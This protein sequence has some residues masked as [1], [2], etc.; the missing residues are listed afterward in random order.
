MKRGKAK[1]RMSLVLALLLSISLVV[2]ACGGND[3]NENNSATNQGGTETSQGSTPETTQSGGGKID[4]SSLPTAELTMMDR[5]LTGVVNQ[6]KDPI[7][8]ELEKIL[9]VKLTFE[10]PAEP[11]Y[12]QALSLLLANGELPDIVNDGYFFNDFTVKAVEE[13]YLAN[14]SDYVFADPDRY[15]TLYKMFNDPLWKFTNK[16]IWG[17]E[18]ANYAMWDFWGLISPP[19]GMSMYNGAVL[20]QVNGG[21]TPKTFDEFIDYLYKVKEQVPGV[22]PLSGRIDAG[23]NLWIMFTSV[24]FRTHGAD[25]YSIEDWNG[26]DVYEETATSDAAKAQWKLIGKLYKDGIMEPDLLTRGSDRIP[27]AVANFANGKY[28]VFLSNAPGAYGVGADWFVQEWKKVDPNV[29]IGKDLVFDQAPIQ[30]PG[31]VAN[32]LLPEIAIAEATTSVSADS[33]YIDRALD[34]L[35]YIMSDEG[36]ILKWYGI[37]G[38]H[39]DDWVNGQAVNFNY[40]KYRDE[41]TQV[42]MPGEDRQEWA[43]FSN[44]EKQMFYQIDAADDLLDAIKKGV[45]IGMEAAAANSPQLAE[46]AKSF[47]D[48]A[49]LQPIYEVFA[50]KV[51]GTDEN[52]AKIQAKVREVQNTWYMKFIVNGPDFVEANWEQFKKELYDAGIQQLIDAKNTE[53]K[54]LKAEFDN[55]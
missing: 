45:S 33:K 25:P 53:A 22:I 14:L 17:D 26:D 44:M 31:G 9:N 42:Y 50:E 2:A 51:W 15:P 29:E 40:E 27:E 23:N 20:Q 18:N 11:G 52:L 13:E 8:K 4:Y 35:N 3:K 46:Y 10:S 48:A 36:Q 41:V 54:A 32:Y 30:G 43:P 12:G 16:Y 37:K 49:K 39:Y 38:V 28:A 5:W 55:M 47:M 7:K 21:E 24:F 34:V 1:A 6:D 19:T